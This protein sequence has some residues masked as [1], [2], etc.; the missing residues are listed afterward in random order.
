MIWLAVCGAFA[1]G[2]TGGFAAARFGELWPLA[3]FATVLSALV[4]YGFACRGWPVVTAFLCGFTLA[5]NVAHTRNEILLRAT[6]LNRG[7]PF[8]GEFVVEGETRRN[9]FATSYG[10]LKLRIVIVSEAGAPFPHTGETWDCAG[11]LERSETDDLSARR[12]VWVKGTGTFARKIRTADR[13]SFAALLRR[14]RRDWSRRM[15]LGLERAEESAGLNRAILLGERTRLSRAAREDFIASGTIHVFAISGLHVMMVA[16]VLCLL[17]ALLRLPKNLSG[18]LV[19]PA[20]WFYVLL[21]GGS[22][23]AVRAASMASLHHA[24]YFTWRRPDA[25]RAWILTFLAV[26]GTD[27]LKIADVGCA[28]SF[29]VMFGIVVWGAFAT[30]F[31]GNRTAANLLMTVAAWS[32]GVPI[33]AHVFGRITPGG[34]FANL[35]MIPAAGWSVTAG[36]AGI[37]VSFVSETLAGYVNNFAALITGA[38]AGVSSVVAA[39]PGANFEI[40]PWS[41]AVC[42][43]WYAVMGLT[44]GLLTHV[45]E[46]RRRIL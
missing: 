4:G 7:A 19:I 3:A 43:E 30:R 41:V 22:P 36:I 5:L 8:R 34:I 31:V 25:L 20:L 9:S 15:G 13:G 17:A 1:A 38:M 37:A 39:I 16:K 45:M 24:A 10:P 44:L 6:E 21:T 26:Y 33:A 40:A 46:R 2:E 29:A 12:T 11:W 18:F 35:L 28:L 14:I 42:I 23:S 32:V 27:P